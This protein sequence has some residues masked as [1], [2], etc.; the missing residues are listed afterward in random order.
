MTFDEWYDKQALV[1]ID[2]KTEHRSTWEAAMQQ[3]AAEIARLKGVIAK[4][5]DAVECA[6]SHDL[7]YINKCKEALAAVKEEGL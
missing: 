5:K 4:C 6:L 2:R 3:Q 7:P 1:L